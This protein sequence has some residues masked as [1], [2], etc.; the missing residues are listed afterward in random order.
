MTYRGEEQGTNKGKS[1]SDKHEVSTKGKEPG[2][3]EERKRLCGDE[4][5]VISMEG[6]AD[7]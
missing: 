6:R 4:W 7:K 2:N 5:L 3:A 1:S